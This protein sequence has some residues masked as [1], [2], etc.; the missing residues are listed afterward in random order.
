MFPSVSGS[1]T[2]GSLCTCDTQKFRSSFQKYAADQGQQANG[3][4]SHQDLCF[5]GL[6]FLPS[7]TMRCSDFSSKNSVQH[8]VHCPEN[9]CGSD[10]EFSFLV[11]SFSL[12]LA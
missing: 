11:M 1:D 12:I 6:I 3:S 9:T 10:G 2:C 5:L 4:L 8:E 7:N